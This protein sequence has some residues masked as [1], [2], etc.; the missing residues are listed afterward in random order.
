MIPERSERSNDRENELHNQLL[1]VQ[2]SYG[3]LS[4]RH[5]KLVSELTRTSEPL[6]Q[7]KRRGRECGRPA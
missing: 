2:E 1:D 6:D 3:A 7:V 5:A 4:Q